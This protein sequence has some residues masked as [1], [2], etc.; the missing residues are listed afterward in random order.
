[1]NAFRVNQFIK[2]TFDDG[3]TVEKNFGSSEEAQEA[4]EF[5]TS[6]N[7]ETEIKILFLGEDPDRGQKLID[8]VDY[9]EILTR[10]GASVYMEDVSELSI[11]DDL[12]EKI[13][14]AEDN[15]DENAIRRYRNFWT[16][17][18]LNPDSRVRNNLFWFIRKWNMQ[19]TDSGLIKAYRNAVLKDTCKLT[20]KQ[21]RDIIN[22]YYTTKYLDKK[23]P[24]TVVY[25]VNNVAKNLNVWYDEVVNSTEGTPTYT[26]AH[27]HSTEIK[28]GRPV[29]IARDKCDADQEHSCSRGLHVGA[30]GWLKQNYYGDVGL[31][32]LVNPANVVAVPTIDEYGKMRTCEYL[33][34]AIIDFDENGDVIE[35]EYDVHTDI[36]YLKQIQYEG[37]INN[38]DIDNYVIQNSNISRE[39]MYASIIERLEQEEYDY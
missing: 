37:D 9:S 8:R 19:I 16:L 39:D 14:D 21:V 28:L 11:P 31:M 6:D 10:R 36:A 20:T 38:N 2:V 5:V 25:Q 18:S 33:P 17:V 22:T 35:P 7:S 3:T 24:G 4:W 30:K 1:M 32:V 23:D 15:E 29:T 34:V 26:D 13:L 12:V 27:S